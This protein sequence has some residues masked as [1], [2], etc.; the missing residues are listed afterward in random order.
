M[1]YLSLLLLMFTITVS[2][3][4]LIEFTTTEFE[5]TKEDGFTGGK[6][7]KFARINNEPKV[8]SAPGLSA[9]ELYQKTLNWVNETYQG[10]E[11]VVLGS[12]DG[13]YIRFQGF[14]RDMFY[15][16]SLGS[17]SAVPVKYDVIVRFRDGR[18]RWEY[19]S[20]KYPTTTNAYMSSLADDY[21]L[22][23]YRIT[24]AN[25]KLANPNHIIAITKGKEGMARMVNRLAE[26]V[27]KA[28][29]EEL[30]W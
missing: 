21:Y 1:K 29:E 18:L 7:G 25:G 19:T 11:E 12:I 20:F 10:G 3:Q 14:S 16:Q 15:K 6:V 17:M 23:G 4:D 8:V 9:A 13:E 22:S 30:D 2:G 28:E 27:N 24:K 5:N 26:Y